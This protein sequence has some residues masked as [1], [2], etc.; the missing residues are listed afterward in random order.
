MKIKICIIGAGYMAQEYLKVLK[1]NRFDIVGIVGRS[2]SNIKKILDIKKVSIFKD[3]NEMYNKTRAN[4]VICAVNE[5]YTFKILSE[6]SK[7]NWKI[8]CEKPLG[9]NYI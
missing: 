3:I 7:Y 1:I 4:A 6:L 2:E 9:I 8:L 5:I